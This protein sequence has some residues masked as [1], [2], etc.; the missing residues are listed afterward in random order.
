V[1]QARKDAKQA[2]KDAKQAAEKAAE[3]AAEK[4]RKD[5]EYQDVG[6]FLRQ[7]GQGAEELEEEKE[8]FP[9]F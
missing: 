3:Q 4:A 5:A 8:V 6:R 7:P 2:R 9:L 1:K